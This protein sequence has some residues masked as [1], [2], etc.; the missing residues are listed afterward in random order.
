MT[1]CDDANYPTPNDLH[2]L[3]PTS[4]SGGVMGGGPGVDANG[5]PAHYGSLC[6]HT[7]GA[8]NPL[9]SPKKPV[10]EEIIKDP[11]FKNTKADCVYGKLLASSTGFKKMIQKFDGAFPVSHLKFDMAN[12]GSARGV[13]IAPNSNS[14]S[15]NSPDYVITI[16]LNNNSTTSGI[17][18]RPNLMIAKTI[19]YKVIRAEMY[20]KLMSLA[21]SNRNIDVNKLKTMLK[22]G[23][24]PG[25]LD[26]YT[27]YGIR[28]FQH[29]QMAAHYR[30]TIA[31][32][33]KGFDNGQNPYQLYLDLAWEGLNHS[34]N[35]TWKNVVSQQ[36]RN[37]I[38]KNIADYISQNKN[39]KCN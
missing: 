16:R 27:R 7:S 5:C 2:T 24:Y 30:K 32:A 17:N 10:M 38:N 3:S 9:P 21:G 26:Y 35:T 14:G 39:Q 31:D 23:D 33:L 19:V 1:V 25:M 29:Q 6:Y 8:G 12:I 4:Q 37:R 18:Y 15:Y 11:S 20:R 34:D 22:N 28:G 13:T 36:E